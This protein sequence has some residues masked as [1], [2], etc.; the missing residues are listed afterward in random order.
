VQTATLDWRAKLEPAASP[1][2]WINRPVGDELS[3]C[4]RY[5]FETRF[6]LGDPVCLMAVF[7]TAGVWGKFLDL[8]VE[9]RVTPTSGLSAVG[10]FRP[11]SGGAV[12]TTGTIDR[13]SRWALSTFNGLTGSSGLSSGDAAIITSANAAAKITADAEL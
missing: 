13:P 11:G 6:P 7:S 1:S 12:F 3:L 2:Q 8:P 5:Y 9:M 10:H 4:Q